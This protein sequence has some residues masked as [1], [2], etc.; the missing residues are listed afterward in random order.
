MKFNFL[1]LKD[2]IPFMGLR[3][4]SLPFR[5]FFIL[6]YCY[7]ASLSNVLLVSTLLTKFANKNMAKLI[8]TKTKEYIIL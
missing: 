1:K 2:T 6:Q 4:I 7:Y 5:Y 3:L 8:V